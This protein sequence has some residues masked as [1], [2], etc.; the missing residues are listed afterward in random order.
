MANR[1]IEVRKRM[2][3]LR[4]LI[5]GRAVSPQIVEHLARTSM[6]FGLERY[7]PKLDRNIIV[8]L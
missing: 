2:I 1:I 3:T 4:I 8:V 6:T 7:F 5:I